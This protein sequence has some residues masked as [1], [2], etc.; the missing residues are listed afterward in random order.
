MIQ[1]KLDRVVCF[2]KWIKKFSDYALVAQT[3]ITFD[4]TPLLLQDS[5]YVKKLAPFRFKAICLTHPQLE[6]LIEEWWK[7]DI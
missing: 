3:K 7:I 5:P 6:D 2:P 4:H 1:T